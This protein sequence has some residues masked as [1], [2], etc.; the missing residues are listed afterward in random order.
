KE[1]HKALGAGMLQEWAEL[2]APNTF[3]Q[4]A[5]LYTGLKLA[6]RHPVV[7]NLVISNVPGPPLPIYLLG[8]RVRGMYPL[9]PVFHGAGLNITV[10]SLAG[11]IDIGMI[12]AAD[13]VDDVWPLVDAVPRALADLLRA[14]DH[15]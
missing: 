3:A 1:E 15:V 9:G 6:E 4:A 5:R 14:A 2:A 7:H 8:A 11:K 12:A 13:L 10:V